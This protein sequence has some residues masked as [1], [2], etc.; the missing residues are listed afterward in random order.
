MVV[1]VIVD[2]VEKHSNR[3]SHVDLYCLGPPCQSWSTA[4]TKAGA[5]DKRGKLLFNCGNYVSDKRPKTVI[6]ENVPG[7]PRN[8]RKQ[9]DKL[10]RVFEDS[11]YVVYWKVLNA[12]DHNLP[13]NR[14][15]MYLVAFS[16]EV[17]HYLKQRPFL[18]PRELEH[19]MPLSAVLEPEGRKTDGKPESELNV[20][21]RDRIKHNLEQ[22][23]TCYGINTDREI[24]VSDVDASEAYATWKAGIFPCITSSRAKTGGYHLSS[25]KRKTCTEELMRAQGM[26]PRRLAD[27]PKFMGVAQFRAAVG[28]AMAVTVLERLIAPVLYSAG[29]IDKPLVDRHTDASWRPGFLS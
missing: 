28:N 26:S 9:F 7:L 18:F 25:H 22:A 6:L 10:V 27:W 3:L 1:Q 29:L 20:S 12:Y 15:R 2:S 19:H 16:T 21:Q 5:H 17:Q 24:I 4:G 11:G 14:P 23:A 8:F 13:Q